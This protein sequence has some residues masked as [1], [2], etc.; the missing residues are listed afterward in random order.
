MRESVSSIRNTASASTG[1]QDHHH[2]IIL[3]KKSSSD[4]DMSLVMDLMR[5]QDS[6][7]LES[8]SM[9]EQKLL[10][11]IDADNAVLAEVGLPLVNVAD[12]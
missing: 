7:E 4:Q 10:A 11:S 9:K 5:S 12:V 8:T 1:S 3:S 2:S 6:G